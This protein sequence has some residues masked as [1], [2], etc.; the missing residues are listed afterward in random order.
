MKPGPVR[1][2]PEPGLF[3]G[4][5]RE[6]SR[7]TSKA[8]SSRIASPPPAAHEIAARRAE[9]ASLL[10]RLLARWWLTK[11]LPVAAP[12]AETAAAGPTQDPRRRTPRSK[13]AS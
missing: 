3:I 2:H 10:G 5:A 8:S 1:L 11:H 9:L 13:N 6:R 4:T 12:A 7:D